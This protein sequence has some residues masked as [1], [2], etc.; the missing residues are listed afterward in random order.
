MYQIPSANCTSTKDRKARR[1]SSKSSRML[2]HDEGSVPAFTQAAKLLD[3]RP[4]V[5]TNRLE[6]ASTHQLRPPMTSIRDTI[7]GASTSLR[8]NPNF[9]IFLSFFIIFLHFFIFPFSFFS[10]FIFS[11]F[12]LFHFLSHF[13]FHC[14]VPKIRFFGPQF[15]YDFS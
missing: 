9:C 12:S 10:F 13:I 7:V 5:S 4:E 2:T 11:I 6:T 3:L 1:N 14:W 15:R 8:L